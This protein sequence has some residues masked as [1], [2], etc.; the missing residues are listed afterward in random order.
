MCNNKIS[1]VLVVGQTPPPYHGQSVMTDL[2]LQSEFKDLKMIHVRMA[3]SRHIQEIEKIRL[4]K[5][6]HLFAII[7][8]IMA[9]RVRYNTSTLYYLPAGPSLPAIWRDILVLMLSRWLF[10]KTIFHFHAGGVSDFLRSGHPFTS[11]LY[12]RVLSSPD[13]CIL[14]SEHSPRDDAFVNSRKTVIIPNGLPDTY[15]S[16]PLSSRSENSAPRILLSGTLSEP[17]GVLVLLRACSILQKQ[18]LTFSAVLMGPFQSYSIEKAV[19][20]FVEQNHLN[21]RVTC[22]GLRTENDKWKIYMNA[23]IFCFPTYYEA[24]GHPLVILEAMQFGLP[25]IAT[26]WRGIPSIVENNCTG[27]LVPI[28]DEKALAAKIGELVSNPDLRHEMGRNGRQRFLE[29]FTVDKWRKR[30]EDMFLE[31]VQQ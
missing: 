16:V 8:R 10:K 17:K 5:I 12:R 1:T 30:M 18:G 3:F 11:W 22:T 9:E 7:G 14:L 29:H 24:E 15:P 28:K 20:C 21:D 4:H 6:W 2:L 23:D 27:M 13:C 31:V 19:A 26:S 25:V